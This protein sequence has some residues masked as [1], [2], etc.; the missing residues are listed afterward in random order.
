MDGTKYVRFLVFNVYLGLLT[1][2]DRREFPGSG[3]PAIAT[4]KQSIYDERHP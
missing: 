2:W 4:L 3:K 1:R